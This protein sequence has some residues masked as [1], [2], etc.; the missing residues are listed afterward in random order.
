M[1]N[2][3][4]RLTSLI[5]RA[6]TTGE[7]N[8]TAYASEVWGD[9]LG[10]H[11]RTAT[12]LRAV[13]EADHVVDDVLRQVALVDVQLL[14]TVRPQLSALHDV[15]SLDY[16]EKPWRTTVRVFG[17]EFNLALE[18]CRS[19]LNNRILERPLTRSQIDLIRTKLEELR[20]ELD[21]M[22]PRSLL[23]YLIQS[24]D[25]IEAALDRYWL[26]GPEHL[27]RAADSIV[28]TVSR[29]VARHP[30]VPAQ[31][32]GPLKRLGAIAGGLATAVT[33]S[34]GL[35]QLDQ[36]TLHALPWGDQPDVQ[37]VKCVLQ[38][39]TTE[40]PRQAPSKSPPSVLGS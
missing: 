35:V 23:V 8:S 17:N 18:V 9:A 37:I 14:D 5:D 21:D 39:P 28:G 36:A 34:L 30:N 4:E 11:P 29:E 10:Q 13:A 40:E 31:H 26:L 27:A 2:A 20:A 24:I 15:F 1:T 19:T 32:V 22:L 7:R 6:K 3:A 16:L 25:E 12:F 38:D 33:I